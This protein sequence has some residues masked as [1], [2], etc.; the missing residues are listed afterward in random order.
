[1]GTGCVSLRVVGEL[2]RLRDRWTGLAHESRLS[3]RSKGVRREE[4]VALRCTKRD[5]GLENGGE[6]SLWTLAEVWIRDS[7][8]WGG[9]CTSPPGYCTGR[10]YLGSEIQAAVAVRSE[11]I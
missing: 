7:G 2:S 3:V 8:L 9:L 11:L 10:M 1:V 5:S 4:L 6:W